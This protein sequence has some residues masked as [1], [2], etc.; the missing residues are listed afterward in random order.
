MTTTPAAIHTAPTL[1]AP[2]ATRPIALSADELAANLTAHSPE[3]LADFEWLR[4]HALTRSFSYHDTAR[5]LHK[6]SGDP[7]SEN[8]LRQA[9]TGHRG[10]DQNLAPLADA[11]RRYRRNIEAPAPTDGFLRT[12]LAANIATYLEQCRHRA[13]IGF[14][15]GENAC[16]KTTALAQA[17]RDDPRI[18]GVRMPEGGH[19]SA[20]LVALARRRGLGDRQTIRNLANRLIAEFHPGDL[21]AIDEGDECFRARSTLLGAKTL[22]FIRRL[23]D[24][25]RCGIVFIMDPAG[26]RKLRDVTPDDPLRRL[27]S[28]RTQPLLLPRFYREDLDLFAARHGLEPAPTQIVRARYQT[29]TGKE[30]T[31]EDSPQRVQDHVCASHHD[32]LFIWLDI[33]ATAALD[34]RTAGKP[35]TWPWVLKSYALHLAGDPEALAKK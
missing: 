14:I 26:F 9:M 18:T 3:I 10:A 15:V 5:H 6:P 30:L 32:G 31:Y 11:I 22:G 23:F 27:Y 33:L 24:E 1:L 7:Y 13:K 8:S 19:L 28:R 20:F 25:A 21:L 12:R 35:L 17:E 34:A 4:S 16:G 29:P 2:A